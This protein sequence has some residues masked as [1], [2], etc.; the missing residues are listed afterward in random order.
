MALRGVI[1]WLK[2]ARRLPQEDAV[3]VEQLSNETPETEEQ[4]LKIGVPMLSR[5]ANSDDY[6]PLRME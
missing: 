6:D 5:I 4:I 3:V 1:P 2:S